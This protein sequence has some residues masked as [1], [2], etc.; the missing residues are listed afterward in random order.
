[1]ADFMWSLVK[2][3]FWAFGFDHR[4]MWVLIPENAKIGD[5]EKSARDI[6][7]WRKRLTKAQGQYEGDPFLLG[8]V[9]LKKQGRSY[10]NIADNLN[11][12]L[13]KLLRE[14]CNGP[15]FHLARCNAQILLARM[16]Y[17]HQEQN[18][19]QAF[20]DEAMKNIRQ[21]RDPFAQLGYPISGE[22]V[23]NVLRPFRKE[24]SPQGSRSLDKNS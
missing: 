24:F 8:L 12:E 16:G 11:S 22:M 7:G 15:D 6:I 20:L 1:M 17:E 9:R 14:C 21:N 23:T 18:M 13:Q 10:Q 4:E 2:T 19:I 5:I 3:R